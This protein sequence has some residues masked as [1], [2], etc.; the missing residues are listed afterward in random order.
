MRLFLSIIALLLSWA[1]LVDMVAAVSND[2]NVRD[3]TQITIDGKAENTNL[4]NFMGPIVDFF[5]VPIP[6]GDATVGNIFI[7][8]AG[9]IKNF[10][11]LIAVLFLII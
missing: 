7:S 5:Y 4:S 9:G 10:F 2:L 8:V 3:T 6:S 11:I 1:S